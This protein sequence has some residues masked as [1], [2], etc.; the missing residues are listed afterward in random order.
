MNFQK[1]LND[2]GISRRLNPG[3]L[4]GMV[5]RK[6]NIGKR[7]KENAITRAALS[8]GDGSPFTLIKTSIE[9][10]Q[11]YSKL[12]PEQFYRTAFATLLEY[13]DHAPECDSHEKRVEIHHHYNNT[14]AAVD[15]PQAE[16]SGLK[17]K[18]LS[19]KHGR[20]VSNKRNAPSETSV[21]VKRSAEIASENNPTPKP[22]INRHRLRFSDSN[23]R[24]V[25]SAPWK[26]PFDSEDCDTC[27]A[28][29]RRRY[30]CSRSDC[31]YDHV[32]GSHPVLNSVENRFVRGKHPESSAAK[33]DKVDD[34]VPTSPDY[35]PDF[36]SL[37]DF[38]Q[39]SSPYKRRRSTSCDSVE[40]KRPANDDP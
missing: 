36:D 18:A 23:L 13:L 16:L 2:T 19:L 29:W 8:L 7:Q 1:K 15:Q 10:F 14:P 20:K 37:K 27:D 35:A 11:S 32:D 24:S 4:L 9:H 3:Q 21:V 34:H 40:V 28:L 5:A 22:R 26:C 30:R 31:K 17:L 38:P 39:L 33:E 6:V 12:A 25:S